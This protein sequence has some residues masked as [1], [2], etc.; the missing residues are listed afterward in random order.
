MGAQGLGTAGPPAAWATDVD[1]E[2]AFGAAALGEGESRPDGDTTSSFFEGVYRQYAPL[3]R[4][5]VYSLGGSED[6]EDIVQE[7]FIRLWRAWDRFEGRSSRRTWVYRVTLNTARGHWR[8]RGRFKAALRRWLLAVPRSEA[9]APGQEAWESDAEVGRAL[10][11]LEPPKREAL[12][13]V[14]LEGLS[15][16]EAAAV[17]G[18]PEGTVKSRLF[19]AREELRRALEE[20]HGTA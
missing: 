6:L 9:V 15:L 12:V 20:N 8:G 3:V 7:V 18:V 10:K 11:A 4:R 17:L 5:T 2:A 16:A 1:A 13:L 14:H 19:H